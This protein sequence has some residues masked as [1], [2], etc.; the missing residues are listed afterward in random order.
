MHLSPTSKLG[1]LSF[2]V[3]SFSDWKNAFEADIAV[4]DG[5][6]ESLSCTSLSVETVMYLYCIRNPVVC[7]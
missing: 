1:Y 7:V 5:D 2:K 4:N 3:T 6:R